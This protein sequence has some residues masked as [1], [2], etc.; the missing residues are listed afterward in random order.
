MFTDMPRQVLK[1]AYIP[2]VQI[3]ERRVCRVFIQT[4]PAFLAGARIVAAK[5]G[6]I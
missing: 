5:E 2:P 4:K 3:A 6:G 1:T